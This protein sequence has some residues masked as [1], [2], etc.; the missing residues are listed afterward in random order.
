L[1]WS[2]IHGLCAGVAA[3]PES[4]ATLAKGVIP[5]M[6]IQ[7]YKVTALAFLA[8]AG[9]LGTVVLAQ[10]GTI[11]GELRG[12][13]NEAVVQEAAPANAPQTKPATKPEPRALDELERERLE[14]LEALQRDAKTRQI[15]DRLKQ[16]IDM[17]FDHP[18]PL[19]Q[20]LKR[21]KQ[22]TTDATFPGIPIYVEPDGLQLAGVNL[23]FL[24]TVP[25]KGPVEFLLSSALRQL[26]LSYIVKD[27]FLMI[28]S[29]D[30]IADRRLD[31]VEQKVDRILS[32][33]ER[34]DKKQ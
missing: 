34:L 4:I 17:G 24:V 23:S 5:T 10:Q 11:R 8:G 27:G 21:V 1:R 13:V 33:L 9:L 12:E 3:V 31:D 25:K 29:R 32:I 20:V 7:G 22:A 18:T 2:A 6:M 28:S 19:D 16:V 30:D 26:R 14:L 15:R